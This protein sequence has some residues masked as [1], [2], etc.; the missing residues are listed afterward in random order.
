MV[1]VFEINPC[2]AFWWDSTG[3]KRRVIKKVNYRCTAY[4]NSNNYQWTYFDDLK[5]NNFGLYMVKNTEQRAGPSLSSVCYD[6]VG[7]F[8]SL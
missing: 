7:L 5:N 4:R 6:C 2:N 8:C 1:Q 3:D